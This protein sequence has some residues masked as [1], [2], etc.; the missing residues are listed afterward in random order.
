MHWKKIVS[1]LQIIFILPYNILLID[2]HDLFNSL[3]KK[4]YYRLALKDHPDRV[5]ESE[6]EDATEKF[7]VLTKLNEMLTDNDKRKL[8]DEKGIIDDDDDQS[9][10]WL[11]LWKQFFKP[12][13]TQDINNYEKEYIGSELEKTDIKKAYLNGKGCI[14][15][16]MNCVPFMRVE[17][18]PRIMELVKGI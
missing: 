9:L 5:P 16:M 1:S 3:V 12:I 15:Y 2:S 4:A 18:E 11:E 8:Y 17:D 13:T 10:C 14:N 7:K 6:K